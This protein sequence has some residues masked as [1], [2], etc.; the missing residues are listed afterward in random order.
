MDIRPSPIAGTWYPADPNTLGKSVDRFLG[1]KPEQA[2]A[3]ELVGLAVPHAG[4]QYSGAVAGRAFSLARGLA[5]ELVAVISPMHNLAPAPV[6]TTAHRAYRTPL[7]DVPVDAGAVQAVSRALE[8]Q[9]GFGIFPLRN[10]REHSLEIE[11]PFLQRV[12]G[13]FQLLPVMILDQREE[14][15]EA[16]GLALAETLAGRKTLL[17]ASSDLSHFYPA[18]VAA[19]L[20]SEILRRMEAFDPAGVMRAEDENAGFACGRAAIAAMLWAARRLGADRVTVVA[21]ATSGDVT[22]DS[23]SVVGYGSAAVWRG[24][25]AG[26]HSTGA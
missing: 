3:G 8:K 24:T 11:L 7:G 17:V 4:H 1:G 6:L 10:D 23:S 25:G 13:E 12:L 9:T 26:L 15:A 21:Y 22:G 16:L 2:P 14:T 5:P 19:K 20:D 18:D